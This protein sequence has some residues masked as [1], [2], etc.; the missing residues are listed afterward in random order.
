MFPKICTIKQLRKLQA[1]REVGNQSGPTQCIIIQAP[2]RRTVVQ[3]GLAI[4]VISDVAICITVLRMS[5]DLR[6][7]RFP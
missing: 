6:Q 5:N 4:T 1:I 7:N 3:D 2:N